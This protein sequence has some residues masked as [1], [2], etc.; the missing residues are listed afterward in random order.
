MPQQKNC[1][2]LFEK[3]LILF[4][5]S[6]RL[7]RRKRGSVDIVISCRP[8]TFCQCFFFRSSMH[9]HYIPKYTRDFRRKR[10]A[11]SR[12]ERK[13]GNVVDNVRKRENVSGW[14]LRVRKK[15]D[16]STQARLKEA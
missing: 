9:S 10:S 6:K 5:E 3:R 15:L 13:D 7:L 11:Y 1:K 8:I 12:R 4:R 2:R 14:V 16:L